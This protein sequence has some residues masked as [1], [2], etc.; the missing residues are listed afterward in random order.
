M[1]TPIVGASW[2]PKY[3]KSY[4]AVNVGVRSFIHCLKVLFALRHGLI[5][6][7]L[8]HSVVY[9]CLIC[10]ICSRSSTQRQWIPCKTLQF[11]MPDMPVSHGRGDSTC[12]R[13]H[14]FAVALL[15]SCEH[16]CFYY[17]LSYFTNH[18]TSHNSKFSS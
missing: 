2:S 15:L 13:S 4:T 7:A 18:A 17:S 9:F 3:V 10:L 12:L 14:Q 6:S 16:V 5:S 11:T 1:M 8:C